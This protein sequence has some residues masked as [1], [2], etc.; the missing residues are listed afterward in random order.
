MRRPSLAL[1]LLLLAAA[2]C[3]GDVAPASSPSGSPPPPVSATP[4]SG[5]TFGRGTV[6]IQTSSGPVTFAVEVAESSEAHAQGLMG[7]TELAP[8]AGMIFVFPDEQS[9][10]F[11]MKDTPIPLTIAFAASTGRIGTILDMEPCTA[12]PCPLYSSEGSA[13]FALEVNRGRLGELGVETGDVMTL[14]RE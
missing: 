3:D 7:R 8:D 11:W 9:R 10:N 14:V 12:D 6:S 2:A 1:A 5:A 13:Q 4:P